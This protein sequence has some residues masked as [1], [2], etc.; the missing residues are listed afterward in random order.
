MVVHLSPYPQQNEEVALTVRGFRQAAGSLPRLTKV[1]TLVSWFVE[2]YETFRP[3]AADAVEPVQ[4]IA[5]EAEAYFGWEIDDCMRTYS[6]A[7][8]ALW[9]WTSGIGTRDGRLSW[10]VSLNES[11]RRF[12]DVETLE[13]LIEAESTG[14]GDRHKSALSS[15]FGAADSLSIF[16]EEYLRA[17]LSPPAERE[18][19]PTLTPSKKG[20][21]RPKLVER[22]FRRDR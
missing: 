22:L 16:D 3:K 14:R 11:L 4:A 5:Q 10:S 18:S 12:R 1:L 7:A 20:G 8:V 9:G 17:T 2:R 19:E 6:V 21:R 15:G 13:E